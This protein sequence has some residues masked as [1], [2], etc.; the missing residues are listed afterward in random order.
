MQGLCHADVAV[1]KACVILV[2]CLALPVSAGVAAAGDQ[3][4]NTPAPNTNQ[5]AK[6]DTFVQPKTLAELLALPP[7]R[8]EEVDIA[9]IDLLCAEGLPGA[10]DLDVEKC[11]ETLDGWAR[12]VKTETD[13]NY[14]RFLEH[15]E[16]F[17]N[18]LG[19]FQMAAMAAVL[20][21]DLR[22][23]YN[24][25]RERE[26]FDNRFF[27][28]RTVYG[29]AER[30]FFSD[31]SDLFLNGIL[32]PKR[33]GTCASLPYLY[34]AVGRRLGYPVSIAGAH[35]HSYV[36]YDE[37][38]G[39]H[40]NVEA[41]ENRAFVTPSDESYKHPVWGAPSSP[42]YYEK[43]GLLR[44]LSNKEAMGHI[45]AERA[46][47]FRSAGQHDEE[48]KTWATAARY[49]PDTPTWKE[50]AQNMQQCAKL[51][52]YQK[53]RDGVWKELSAYY[54]PHGPGFAYFRD[55]KIKLHLFMNESLDRRAVEQAAEEYK[56]ELSEY[57]RMVMPPPDSGTALDVSITNQPPPEGQQLYFFYRPP[58]G[59]QV[60]V[61]ADFMPPFPH[62]DLPTELK[63]LIVDSK[64]RDTDTLLEMVWQYYEHMQALELAKQKAE[65]E[66]IA[67]GSP[68]LISEE[69]IPPEFRNGV[70]MELG[71]R[72]SGLHNAQEI[73]IEMLQYKQQQQAQ[74]RQGMMADPT[75]GLGS[76]LRQ[77]GV[78]DSV[79]RIA[80]LPV[81]DPQGPYD[82]VTSALRQSGI[83]DS[84]ARMSGL[85]ASRSPG[86]GL[87]G[88]GG[89][90][91][92]NPFDPTLGLAAQ[93]FI[94][95]ASGRGLSAKDVWAERTR[96]ANEQAMEIFAQQLRQSDTTK[97]GIAL[98]Y[99]V[100]PASVAA[101]NP[102]VQN[103]MP[104]AGS[105]GP[106]SSPLTTSPQKSIT[107]STNRTDVP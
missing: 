56:K 96:Q 63:Q 33:Y 8:L 42:E 3:T 105:S 54:I 39:K 34:V 4:T 77:A 64:P 72:L 60:K 36:Y 29:E 82:Q 85:P 24:P 88:I 86:A 50:I 35:M 1:Q 13:K 74:Q 99:Q 31:S 25:Q 22:V 41:T 95:G 20:S 106:R 43:R 102:M 98:P 17:K 2:A 75:G 78:P 45:L 52:E 104:F 58:D 89:M 97:P 81:A 100:V 53:W 49:F 90:P 55:K 101:K 19:R 32:S 107:T 62:R 38:D 65:V 30:S 11:I 47:V 6:A 67:S 94:P 51:D 71:L 84:V 92:M 83:P 68:I 40:F 9:R 73:V 93:G 7:D 26:L 10:E 15:P 57:S 80:G 18:S 14:H 5:T 27:T 87:P 70:P 61:P 46:A 28:N 12:Y 79:A 59:N 21:E 76:V 66:R 91:G 48:A 23:Q 69:S 16:K 37:G 44:P 103:P